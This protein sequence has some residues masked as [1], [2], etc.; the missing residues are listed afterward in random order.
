M[1]SNKDRAKLRGLA[2]TKK[3][4]FNIGKEGLGESI[5]EQVSNYLN[6]HEL[7]KITVLNNADADVKEIAIEI[8]KALNA[9]L[10]ETKGRTFVLYKKTNKD[11]S[12]HILR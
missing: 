4:V 3:A 8:S 9:E 1:L 12:K 10:V 6:A 5:I 7:I 11:N 2:S